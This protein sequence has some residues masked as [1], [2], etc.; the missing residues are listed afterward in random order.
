LKPPTLT[1]IGKY[2]GV[3]PQRAQQWKVEG[4]PVK[5]L[6]AAELWRK[7]RGDKRVAVNAKSSARLPKGKRGRP[8][9]KS[10][11]ADTG[12][13]LK[14]S[15][16]DA[17]RISKDAFLAYQD[18]DLNEKSPR[19][20]EFN[21]ALNGRQV[22]ER[23]Y[24]EELQA[25][26]ILVPRAAIVE[27]CRRAMDVMLRRLKKLPNETGPQCEGQ[28]AVNIVTILQKA[29]NDILVSGQRAMNEL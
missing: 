16:M 22:A 11:P 29:V 18:A 26:S 27:S 19:L 12:D 2:L 28:E 8:R 24:R 20:S 21:K 13:T 10:A 14:D 7:A 17:I 23:L 25:R 5:S 1:A 3:T 4:M 9:K 6:R 15:L